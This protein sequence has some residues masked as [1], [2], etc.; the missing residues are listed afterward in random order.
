MASAISSHD[1]EQEVIMGRGT[2]YV[3]RAIRRKDSGAYHYEVDAD[4]L[5]TF[6]DSL[7]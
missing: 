1:N 5:G 4:V 6:P 3:I 2:T 7:D